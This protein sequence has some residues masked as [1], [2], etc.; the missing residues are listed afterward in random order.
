[1]SEPRR[2]RSQA[3]EGREERRKEVEGGSWERRLESLVGVETP[4]ES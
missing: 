4:V 3:R 1:M 2:L